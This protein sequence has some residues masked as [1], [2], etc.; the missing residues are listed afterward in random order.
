MELMKYHDKPEQI[1]EKANGEIVIINERR[2]KKKSKYK[3]YV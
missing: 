2:K 1:V 3:T